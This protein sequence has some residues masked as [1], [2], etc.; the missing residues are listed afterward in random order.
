MGKISD[1]IEDIE[2]ELEELKE[3]NKV[4]QLKIDDLE[5]TVESQQETIQEY[6]TFCNWISENRPD[7]EIA[8]SVAQRMEK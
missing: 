6:Q 4:L 2:N 1:A 3:D 5:E 7:I 8:F